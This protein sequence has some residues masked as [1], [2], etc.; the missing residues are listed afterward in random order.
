M[1]GLASI[2]AQVQAWLSAIRIANGYATD[3]GANVVTE[4]LGMDGRDNAL[5]VGVYLSDLTL[6]NGTPRRRDWQLDMQVEARIP[7]SFKTAEAQA[8]A[9]LEDVVH[10]VPTKSCAMPDNFQMLDVTGAQIQRQPDGV[11]YIVV[12]VTLRGTCYEYTS[13][14]A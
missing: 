9:V 14:P 12:G 7:I 13:S 11:P 8:V 4:A 1:I 3:A 5:V 2:V 6:V 10:A